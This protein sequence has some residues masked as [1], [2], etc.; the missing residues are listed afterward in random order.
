MLIMILLC[1]T[2]LAAPIRKI[3]GTIVGIE[4]GYLWVK[5]DEQNKALKFLL[6]WNTSFTPPRL[7][8]KGD[9]VLVLY[10]HKDGNRVIYGVNYLKMT[11][12]S[13]SGN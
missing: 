6:K 10:K 11:T 2:A 1:Q 9:H 7:P 4:E 12:E 5:P 3:T 13:R 8:I